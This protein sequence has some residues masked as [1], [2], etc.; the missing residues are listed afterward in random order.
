MCKMANEGGLSSSD[1]KAVEPA[2]LSFGKTNYYAIVDGCYKKKQE[3]NLPKKK[4]VTIPN[5]Y[6]DAPALRDEFKAGL[7]SRYLKGSRPGESDWFLK[8]KSV[9][10]NN[11]GR[12][13]MGANEH[14]SR[15]T[16][17]R[18]L[19]FCRYGDGSSGVYKLALMNPESGK[20][21]LSTKL[22]I[23]SEEKTTTVWLQAI[24]GQV[25]TTYI[26]KKACYGE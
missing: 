26:I 15:M 25:Q 22:S 10:N 9:Y 13:L 2:V 18:L 23:A 5:F 4:P 6:E 8:G 19:D 24:L 3:H 20:E 7:T 14:C 1:A 17:D 11:V 16:S 12:W 21:L